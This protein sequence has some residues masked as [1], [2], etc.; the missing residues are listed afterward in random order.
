MLGSESIYFAFLGLVGALLY[1][2]VWSTEWRDLY[3]YESFRHMA[4]GF[5]SGFIYS[6]LH[7]E[8]NFPNSVM[9]VVVGYFGPD[10]IEAILERFKRVVE[11]AS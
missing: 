9:S 3:S 8:H 10:L 5:I 6:L 4:I 11:T 7:S 2:L 1:I